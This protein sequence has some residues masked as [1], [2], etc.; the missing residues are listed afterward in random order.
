[1]SKTNAKIWPEFI[2]PTEDLN[3]RLKTTKV[4][5]RL[6]LSERSTKRC[7]AVKCLDKNMKGFE[8]EVYLL[9]LIQALKN[10]PYYDNLL[11]RFLL[12]RA[13]RSQRIGFCL[14]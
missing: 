6:I 10:E 1:L 11:I 5:V 13:L 7:F 12:N 2:F 9:Q 14:F 3:K 8:I 4:N